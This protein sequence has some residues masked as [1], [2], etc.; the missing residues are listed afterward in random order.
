E[1]IPSDF[2]SIQVGFSISSPELP[3]GGLLMI[4]GF[5]LLIVTTAAVGCSPGVKKGS[6]GPG[7][8]GGGGATAGAIP[9][10][11][12]KAARPSGDLDQH[13]YTPQQGDCNDCNSLINPGAI[14]IPDDPTDYA[15]NGRPGAPA[16][17]DEL[18]PG[19]RDPMSLAQALDECDPRF[20]IGATLVGP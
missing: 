5:A 7:A 13:G 4:R 1:P 16:S 14:Q 17:C 10:C 12:P 15:C 18:E 8:V 11:D 3:L 9:N 20:L 6:L 2:G 19:L